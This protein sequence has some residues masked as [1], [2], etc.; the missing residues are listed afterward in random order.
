MIAKEKLI[1]P[2]EMSSEYSSVLN[3]KLKSC[4]NLVRTEDI[5]ARDGSTGEKVISVI[6]TAICEISWVS[7]RTSSIGFLI[8]VN[9]AIIC[10]AN[11]TN[12]PLIRMVLNSSLNRGMESFFSC[13]FEGETGSAKLEC[14]FTAATANDF[15]KSLQSW[16]CCGTIL[17]F[18]ESSRA[19]SNE[20]FWYQ[21]RSFETS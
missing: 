3:S 7:W 21:P 4:T 6:L 11:E 17:D 2:N 20:T 15:E 9:N 14:F 16:R 18:K 13:F 8:V 1:Y 12:N 5:F 19:K 10:E